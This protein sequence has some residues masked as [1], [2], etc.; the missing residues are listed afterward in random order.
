ML[1][2]LLDGGPMM[3]PL[4]ALSIL[5]LAVMIERWKVFRAAS[6]DTSVMRRMILQLIAAGK[7]EDAIRLC[8]ETKGPVSYTH[9]TLPTN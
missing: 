5:S 2:Y 4:L 6:G 7:P 8:E 3:W 9:L 1:E